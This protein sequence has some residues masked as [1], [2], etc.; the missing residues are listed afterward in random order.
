MKIIRFCFHFTKNII[1]R[2]VCDELNKD[3]KVMTDT[4]NSIIKVL[5]KREHD[6]LDMVL[7]KFF[8]IAS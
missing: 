3:Y 4:P 2:Y 6:E 7:A 8:L 5:V 1:K